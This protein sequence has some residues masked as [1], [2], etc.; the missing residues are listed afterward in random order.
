[1]LRYYTQDQTSGN[2]HRRGDFG[3]LEKR[4]GTEDEKNIG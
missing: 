1:M 4:I 3:K 2:N